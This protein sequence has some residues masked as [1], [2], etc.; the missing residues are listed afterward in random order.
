MNLN[1]IFQELTRLLELKI[2][3][4]KKHLKLAGNKSMVNIKTIQIYLRKKTG[5]KNQNQ[6]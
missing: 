2:K 4:G 1:L 5:L 3:S 6:N